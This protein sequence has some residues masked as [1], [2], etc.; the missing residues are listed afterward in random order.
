M[1]LTASCASLEWNFRLY[2]SCH[3]LTLCP[4]IIATPLS[5]GPMAVPSL[6]LSS[7]II[8]LHA[9][10]QSWCTVTDQETLPAL[11]D[12]GTAVKRPALQIHADLISGAASAGHQLDARLLQVYMQQPSQVLKHN[13]LCD[14]TLPLV[15]ILVMR[16]LH[17][18]THRRH[19]L[20]IESVALT[21][22]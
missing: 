19:A 13:E 11:A 7:T 15:V 2:Q 4:M 3:C 16:D 18:H 10:G 8:C 22:S 5:D 20:N 14:C 21:F 1:E 9:G 12:A 17:A 6:T